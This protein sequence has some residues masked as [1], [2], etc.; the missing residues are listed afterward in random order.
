MTNTNKKFFILS[1]IFFIA[2]VLTTVLRLFALSAE[3]DGVLSI[4]WPYYLYLTGILVLGCS[5]F[6]QKIT[7]FTAAVAG[8]I[9]VACFLM[10]LEDI[11]YFVGYPTITMFLSIFS[12]LLTCATFLSVLWFVLILGKNQSVKAFW[13]MPFVLTVLD[14][15]ILLFSLFLSSTVRITNIL[16]QTSCSIFIALALL[17][18]GL[19][20]KNAPCGESGQAPTH[21]PLR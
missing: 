6:S 21:T 5:L 16:Y 4:T 15:T 18:L 20:M 17:S 7:R 3:V 9:A 14:K 8:I 12:D 1:G 19:C 10:V 11:R 13:F 2:F